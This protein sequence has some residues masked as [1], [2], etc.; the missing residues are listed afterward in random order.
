[1]S[2]LDPVTALLLSALVLHEPLT[3]AGIVG[4]VLVLGAAVVSELLARRQ[5][6]F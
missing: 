5:K 1:M 3:P 4:A 2:Y 6:R